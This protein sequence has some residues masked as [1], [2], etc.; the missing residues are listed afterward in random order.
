[1]Q[2]ASVE[3]VP[4]EDIAVLQWMQS[5]TSFQKLSVPF[6]I[7]RYIYKPLSQ[8]QEIQKPLLPYRTIEIL[9]TGR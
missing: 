9:T 7:L 2:G 8:I 4:Y 5:P 6:I 1:M 3:L